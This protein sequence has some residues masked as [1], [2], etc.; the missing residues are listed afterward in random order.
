M[1]AMLFRVGISGS[2]GRMDG[3]AW[4]EATSTARSRSWRQ[5]WKAES[6]ITSLP[7]VSVPLLTSQRAG[8]CTSE[9]VVK[10]RDIA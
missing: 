1:W 3:S 8:W 9:R 5:L 4:D 10:Q 6:V 2:R 7:L